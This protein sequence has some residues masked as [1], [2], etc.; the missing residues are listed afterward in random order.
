MDMTLGQALK[1][2][3]GWLYG[4]AP[5]I[6]SI[7]GYLNLVELARVVA[8]ALTAGGGVLAVLSAIGADAAGIFAGPYAP[9]AAAVIGAVIQVARLLNHGDAP[10]DQ[11]R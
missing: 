10:K 7:K 9:A 4:L 2:V 11:A 8:G 5:A 1:A 6:D 3:V